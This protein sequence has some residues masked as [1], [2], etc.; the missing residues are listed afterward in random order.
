MLRYRQAGSGHVP[1]RSKLLGRRLDQMR[2][3]ANLG[4]FKLVHS[5]CHPLK[6]NRMGKWSADLDGPYGLL[7]EPVLSD[8]VLETHDISAFTVIRILQVGV[9]THE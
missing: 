2:Q 4:E 8:S 6:G 7:F 9:N 1:L 3:A 5:R